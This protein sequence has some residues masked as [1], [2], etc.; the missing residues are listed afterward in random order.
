MREKDCQFLDSLFK[1][2]RLYDPSVRGCAAAFLYYNQAAL[3]DVKFGE[4]ESYTGQLK[5]ILSNENIFGID[6]YKAGIGEKIEEL[7]VKEIAGPSVVRK[8][9]KENLTD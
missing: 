8:T 1:S 5:S 2:C 4:E 6:L 9:L 7:F 3:K